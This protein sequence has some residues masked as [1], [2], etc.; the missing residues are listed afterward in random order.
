MDRTSGTGTW[1]AWGTLRQQAT[2]P[3]SEMQQN[4]NLVRFEVF[5]E[6]TMKNGVFWDVTSCGSKVFL[7]SVRRLLVAAS[8]VP[9]SLIL[10]TLMKEELDSS[11]TSVFTRATRHNIPEDTTLQ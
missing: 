6:V 3:A 7:H 8:A 5:T 2:S 10:V 11:E 9:S 4:N 1:L